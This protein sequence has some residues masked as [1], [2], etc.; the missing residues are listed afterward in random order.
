MKKHLVIIVMLAV[1]LVAAAGAGTAYA[2][3]VTEPGTQAGLGDG[4]YGRGQGGRM[5]GLILRPYMQAAVAEGLGISVEDL[6]AAHADGTTGWEIA[7][8]QGLTEAEFIK[9]MEDARTQA[10]AAAV[11]DGAISQELADAM[12][13]RFDQMGANYFS[14]GACDGSGLDR[15]QSGAG[16]GG[17][18]G[19]VR[20][21]QNR[22]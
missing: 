1:L 3:S 5:G 6:E 11:A 2:Q 10:L 19:R 18:G 13:A 16:M 9:V 14:G 7:Q 21:F 8:E 15:V 22:P 17:Q 12:Q 20:N 4:I